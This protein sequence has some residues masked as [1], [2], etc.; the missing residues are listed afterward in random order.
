M[1]LRQAVLGGVLAAA[2]ALP[3]C[4]G[5]AGKVQ[6]PPPG[7]ANSSEYCAKRVATENNCMACTSQPGCGWCNQPVSGQAACQPGVDA[8][9]PAT[10]SD[11]WALSSD[12]CTAPP[13][14]P[15]PT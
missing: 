7:Q 4:G 6:H 1:N 8:A 14:P 10:C 12:Q 9:L 2:A 15:P 5:D 13:P 11:G 3:S